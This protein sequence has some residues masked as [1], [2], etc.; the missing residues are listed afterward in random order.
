MLYSSSYA[1]IRPATTDI[2]RHCR[3]DVLIVGFGIASQQGRSRHDLSWLAIATLDYF[4]IE[5][6]LLNLGSRCRPTDPLD[7]CDGSTANRSNRKLARADRDTIEMNR[8]RA[9]LSDS[10]AELC[11]GEAKNVPKHPK[12]RH[13]CRDV[14]IAALAVD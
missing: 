14:Y 4:E 13:V 3:V 2:A 10:A 8:A 6:S 12:Q 5:P 7:R 1:H 11:T 9:T